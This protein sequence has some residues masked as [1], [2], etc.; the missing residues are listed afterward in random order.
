MLGPALAIERTPRPKCF[1]RRKSVERS[2]VRCCGVQFYDAD[3]FTFDDGEVDSTP[4][5]VFDVPST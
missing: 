4:S 3:H 1:P 2:A 5:N